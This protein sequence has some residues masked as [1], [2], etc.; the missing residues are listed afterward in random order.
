MDVAETLNAA[1]AAALL[2]VDTETVLMLARQ[3]ELPGAKI[4]KPW[5]FL[6]EDVLNYLRSRVA[7]DTSERRR[8]LHATPGR[9]AE[10]MSVPLKTRR[11][12][13]PALP[14]LPATVHATPTSIKAA[15]QNGSPAKFHTASASANHDRL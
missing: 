10:L 6:R 3:G 4:G 5:V 12:P 7:Q 9:V 15:P 8:Q 14:P 11:R 2:F 1:Q 13:P